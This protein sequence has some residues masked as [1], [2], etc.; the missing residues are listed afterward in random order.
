MGHSPHSITPSGRGAWAGAWCVAALRPWVFA[1][2]C[3]ASGLGAPPAGAVVTLQSAEPAVASATELSGVVRLANG[4]S[5]VL[6]A[7][8]RHLLGAAHCVGAVGSEVQFPGTPERVAVRIV[9]TAFAPGWLGTPAVHD[10][11]IMT[12]EAQVHQVAAYRLASEATREAAPWVL[13]AGYGTGGSHGQPRPAGTLGWGR[14]EYEGRMKP[15]ERYGDRVALFDFDDGSFR[16]NTLGLVVGGVSSLGLGPD[17]AMLT[18]L[19]SGGPS[20]VRAPLAQ[21]SGWRRWLEALQRTGE[22]AGHP[23]AERWQIV[24]IHA[25]IDGQRGT[26][27]GG[28]ALDTLVAPYAAWIASIAGPQVLAD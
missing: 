14:N 23:G 16:A 15:A 7:G 4:C 21:A 8:G 26:G 20:L 9:A 25:G 5:A 12:L 27:P 6:L 10:L 18:G 19:D 24:G 3:M 28:V 22:A 17:E 11:A 1:F 2:L 13:V